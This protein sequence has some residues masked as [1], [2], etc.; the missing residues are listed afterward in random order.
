MILTI[1]YNNIRLCNILDIPTT[2]IINKISTLL[3]YLIYQF[4]YL[5]FIEFEDEY[6]NNNYNTIQEIYLDTFNIITSNNYFIIVAYNIYTLEVI[7]GC[8]IDEIDDLRFKNIISPWFSNLIIKSKYRNYG[9]SKKLISYFNDTCIIKKHSRYFLYCKRS[10]IKYY[11][12]LDYKYV[13]T[14]NQNGKTKYV[15]Y[16]QLL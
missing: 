9:L 1:P 4:T 7:G 8:L 3:L 14:F 12:R 13:F 15:F 10:L 16:K 6:K 5:S 11:H 2:S